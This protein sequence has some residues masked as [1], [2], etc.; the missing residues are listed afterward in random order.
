MG[1]N[2][3]TLFTSMANFSDDDIRAVH[4]LHNRD[5]I[6]CVSQCPVCNTNSCLLALC[7]HLPGTRWLQGVSQVTS[8]C[9]HPIHYH[10]QRH[11]LDGTRTCIV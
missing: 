7:L 5:T 8:H 9:T 11:G 6:K 10:T 2:L 1:R 3:A 4:P